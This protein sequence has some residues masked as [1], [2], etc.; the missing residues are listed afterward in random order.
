MVSL[1]PLHAALGECETVSIGLWLLCFVPEGAQ[2]RTSPREP[3]WTSR[4]TLTTIG[5]EGRHMRLVS[6]VGS[7][8]LLV[9]HGDTH[10]PPQHHFHVKKRL[11]VRR[12]ADLGTG[13]DI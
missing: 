4:L 2:S 13:I 8:S 3:E 10:D 12:K 1:H 9:F 6:D 7:T 11:V 5:M